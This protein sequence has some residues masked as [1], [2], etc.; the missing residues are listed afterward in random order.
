IRLSYRGLALAAPMAI[1]IPAQR[2]LAKCDY[3]HAADPARRGRR[4]HSCDL[5][6]PGFA[7]ADGVRAPPCRLFGLK[8]ELSAVACGLHALGGGTQLNIAAL[9]AGAP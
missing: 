6:T 3:P 5:R 9:S 7:E 1:L 8:G 4:E 2:K